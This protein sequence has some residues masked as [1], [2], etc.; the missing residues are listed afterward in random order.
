MKRVI[1]SKG[2]KLYLR[3]NGTW[4]P[5]AEEAAD[6]ANTMA[7]IHA[8]A[9]FS[10]EGVEMILQIGATPNELYDIVLS[11]IDFG[12]PVTSPRSSAA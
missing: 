10:L 9:L 4:T 3:I 5:N 1:R 7:V 6:F 8:K 11:L 2:T 12:G